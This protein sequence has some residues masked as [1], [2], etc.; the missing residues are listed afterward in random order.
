LAAGINVVALN[1][2]LRR[3]AAG[4]LFAANPDKKYV[5]AAIRAA[6]FV[7]LGHILFV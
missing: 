3:A 2:K 1:G 6:F 7:F 4:K 5:A